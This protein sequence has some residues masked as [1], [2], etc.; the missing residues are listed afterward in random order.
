MCNFFQRS[1]PQP[2]SQSRRGAKIT[3]R[4][5]FQGVLLLLLVGSVS[6]DFGGDMSAIADG[7]PSISPITSSVPAKMST[8]TTAK[9]PSTIANTLRKELSKQTGVSA[10]KLQMVQ[11]TPK[12]WS[13]GCLG[14]AKNDEI[15]SQ[16]LVPGWQVVF[17]NGTQRWVYRTNATGRVYRLE[18]SALK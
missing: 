8:K 4:I 16:A 11:S 18:T 7:M 14:L 6:L 13:D 12:T 2:L 1:L 3:A 9:L 5:V 10:N 17:S 15:C